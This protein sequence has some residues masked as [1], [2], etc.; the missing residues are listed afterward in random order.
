[1]TEIQLSTGIL[2]IGSLAWDTQGGRP[3]WRAKRLRESGNISCKVKVPIRYGRLSHAKTGKSDWGTYTMVFARS[4]DCPVGDAKVFPCRSAVSKFEDLWLE[5]QWLWAAEDKNANKELA[6]NAPVAS[7]WG[8]VALLPNPAL[9]KDAKKAT[10]DKALRQEWARR[11][12]NQNHY[13][14]DCEA[15][16]LTGDGMLM[17][18][19]PQ[20]DASECSS[21]PDLLLA[22]TNTPCLNEQRQPCFPVVNT[23][24]RAWY[25]DVPR[26]ATEN[27]DPYV[28][29][30]WCNYHK[31]FRTFQ[32][33]D[34]KQSLNALASAVGDPGKCMPPQS[35]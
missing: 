2:V 16:L 21:V 13:F 23:I 10:L 3:D 19:W 29:Y 12:E 6:A 30:F 26:A 24:V 4:V 28:G 20:F 31:G 32:D 18:D 33:E 25:N 15:R 11:V 35:R 8:C 27:R 7:P 22:T 34:I 14:D 9:P 1:M 17:V 5:A